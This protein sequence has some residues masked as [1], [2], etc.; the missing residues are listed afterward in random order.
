[1]NIWLTSDL[2]LNHN[3]IIK[4]TNRPFSSIEEM[5]NML[6]DNWN[7]VVKRSDLIYVLGDFVWKN[8]SHFMTRLNGKIILIPGS[9]D[10]DALKAKNRRLFHAIYPPLAMGKYNKTSIV[11]CHYCLRTWPKSHFNSIHCF[12][13]SHGRL[14]PIGKSM[15]VG[16]DNHD[17]YPWNVDEILTIMKDK[18]NNFNF[19]G[20]K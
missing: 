8:T 11:M 6:I 16:V 17:F 20:N 5:N 13:H 14:D 9:H 3:N 15:D 18:P 7:S 19:V 4:Y 2:H 12:G 10:S 1:M